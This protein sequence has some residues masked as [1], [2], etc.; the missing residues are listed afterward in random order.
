VQVVAQ[1]PVQL[2]AQPVLDVAAV[3]GFDSRI[4]SCASNSIK[5]SI[6]DPCFFI[7]ALEGFIA[8]I[9]SAILL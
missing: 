5:S 2:A 9:G 7:V 1:S 3:T 6:G 8:I 4:V